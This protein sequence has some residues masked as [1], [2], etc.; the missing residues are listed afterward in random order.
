MCL[1]SYLA[2]LTCIIQESSIVRVLFNGFRSFHIIN[3]YTAYLPHYS[4]LIESKFYQI[5]QHP[6]CV[7]V[8]SVIV[9]LCKLNLFAQF[10]RLRAETFNT[11]VRYVEQ[12]HRQKVLIQLGVF[13]TTQL[14]I[15]Q[16]VNST[17]PAKSHLC[18]CTWGS[19]QLHAC[20][21]E[22]GMCSTRGGSWGM[23]ITFASAKQRIRKRH[24]KQLKI[25]IK[26]RRTY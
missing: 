14:Y 12:N 26:P 1:R 13:L 15:I 3:Y 9:H 24:V 19:D 5:S 11:V 17:S 16:A 22:V 20:C 18:K 2:C 10:Y 6:F 25:Y 23:Y 8:V 4:L 7:C 21:Q